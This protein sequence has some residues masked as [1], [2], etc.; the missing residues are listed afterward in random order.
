M[1]LD[2]LYF[3]AT[4]A[5]KK[6]ISSFPVK[7]RSFAKKMDDDSE[8]FRLSSPCVRGHE[9]EPTSWALTFGFRS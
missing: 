8:F 2:I 6:S 3:P 4:D 7:M 5:A 1:F 9:N